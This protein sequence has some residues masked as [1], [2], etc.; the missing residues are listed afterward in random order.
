VAVVGYSH[1]P[2]M[3]ALIIARVEPRQALEMN[4]PFD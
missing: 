4:A 2:D 1:F 3:K